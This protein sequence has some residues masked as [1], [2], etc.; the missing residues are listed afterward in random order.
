MKKIIILSTF[1][2]LYFYTFTLGA[3][4]Q[5]SPKI[6]IIGD[7]ITLGSYPCTI[8]DEL[9]ITN[10]NFVGPNIGCRVPVLAEVSKGSAYML[11][12]V[13]ENILAIDQEN[14]N[15]IFILLGTNDARGTNPDI[16]YENLLAIIKMVSRSG[17]KIYISTLP[18]LKDKN[19]VREINEKIQ[20][21][22]NLATP[23]DQSEI[24]VDMLS[25]GIHPNEDGQKIIACNFLQISNLKP[26]CQKPKVKPV[27]FTPAKAPT[28][29]K[30]CNSGDSLGFAPLRPDPGEPCEETVPEDSVFACGSS[31]TPLRQEKFD[32]YGEGEGCTV[33]GDTATCYRAL[34]FDVSLD[35]SKANLGILGNTQD[36]NLTDEQKVNEYLS[37][38]LSG[39]PQV[40][41]QTK[42]DA[43]KL[44]N[45]SGPIRKLIPYDLGYAA[46]ETIINENTKTVHNYKVGNVDPLGIV[47][48]SLHDFAGVFSFNR[49]LFKSLFQNIPF[50][51]LEDTVGEYVV[52]ATDLKRNNLQDPD[53]KDGTVK[54][55]IT[56]TA[57]A[58]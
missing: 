15:Y 4:A 26:D 57:K 2:L 23:V 58:P 11:E 45:F 22:S 48:S 3:S 1:I 50:S 52:S 10:A 34:N 35:L 41:D 38:Y 54:L 42:P 46:K 30:K 55:T 5:E 56:S 29:G 19:N 25:D 7:S 53:I 37:W 31:I 13:R 27:T 16:V 18:P 51:S 43:D 6:L 21:L 24:T 12:K 32:P 49:E 17:R 8:R 47:Y 20:L 28:R 33:V 40:G 39:I 44:I 14:P 9:K 36:Q